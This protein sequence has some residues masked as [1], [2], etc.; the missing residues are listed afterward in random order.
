MAIFNVPSLEAKV[1]GEILDDHK[2]HIAGSNIF[3]QHIRLLSIS[4]KM[5]SRDNYKEWLYN[6]L[7]DIQLETAPMEVFIPTDETMEV[8]FVLNTETPEYKKICSR[9][10]L[11]RIFTYI[12][13]LSDLGVKLKEKPELINKVWEDA[14]VYYNL[15]QYIQQIE[16]TRLH[17][18]SNAAPL[19][20]WIAGGKVKNPETGEEIILP[21]N[22]GLKD[23]D[24]FIEQWRPNVEKFTKKCSDIFFGPDLEHCHKF[25]SEEHGDIPVI[26][27]KGLLIKLA[28][29]IVVPSDLTIILGLYLILSFAIADIM[30]DRINESPCAEYV[31]DVISNIK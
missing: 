27:V 11:E 17:T 14:Y 13:E 12:P 19:I 5:M 15:Y 31:R 23:I 16:N 20:E 24:G 22:I 3:H 9:L 6:V 26:D 30:N 2:M 25:Y 7:R 29:N 8:P 18:L 28:T 1:F 10:R 4:D 21:R